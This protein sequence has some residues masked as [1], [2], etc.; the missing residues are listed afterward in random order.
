MSFFLFSLSKS[1][2]ML[3]TFISTILSCSYLFTF[4]WDTSYKEDLIVVINDLSRP[5]RLYRPDS[6]VSF[7]SKWAIKWSCIAELANEEL[8]SLQL[9]PKVTLGVVRLFLLKIEE[10]VYW[11]ELLLF[12][13]I[14]SFL[15][16]CFGYFFTALLSGLLLRPMFVFLFVLFLTFLPF[17]C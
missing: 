15:F 3:S 6:F 7:L 12:Y 8:R 13:F 11:W 1:N 4:L 17:W 5:S 10:L 16:F 14:L 9:T 2:L